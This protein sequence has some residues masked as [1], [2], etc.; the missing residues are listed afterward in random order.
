MLYDKRIILKPK[1]LHLTKEMAKVIAIVISGFLLIL[2][3]IFIKYKPVEISIYNEISD[4]SDDMIIDKIEDTS[5]SI[6]DV[7]AK[8][9]LKSN[10]INML[11]RAKLDDR[12]IEVLILRFG[13]CGC[14][15]QS[16]E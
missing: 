8:R 11:K 3:I 5:D 1:L 7:V 15:S 16:C 12:E 6:E 10:L 4:K 14:E 13:L 2:A 9:Y